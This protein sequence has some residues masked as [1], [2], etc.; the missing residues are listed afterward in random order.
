MLGVEP[1]IE[2]NFVGCSTSVKLVLCTALPTKVMF[3]FSLKAAVIGG[4]STVSR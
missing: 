2:L 1:F 3:E 4:H